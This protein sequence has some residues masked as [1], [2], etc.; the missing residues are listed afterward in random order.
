MG[1]WHWFLQPQRVERDG[2]VTE[3]ECT[4]LEKLIRRGYVRMGEVKSLTNYFSVK[5]V[6][7]IRM[8]Y[9]GKYSGLNSSIWEPNFYLPTVGSTIREVERGTFMEYRDITE[10][11]LNFI[12]GKE[13]RSLCWLDITNVRTKEEWEMYRSGCWERWKQKI[14]GII[15]SPYHEYQAMT[16]DNCIA[17]GDRLDLN[18]TF[19]G[20]RW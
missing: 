10:M 9:N 16:W 19:H 3:K 6:E 18:N 1:P 13:F 17:M 7:D 5:N 20:R 11:F 15:D 8:V 14:M 2:E 12:L 4:K